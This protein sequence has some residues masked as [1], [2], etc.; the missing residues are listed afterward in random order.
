MPPITLVLCLG[1]LAIWA[2]MQILP[3][4]SWAPIA[5]RL[6]LVPGDLTAAAASGDAGALAAQLVTLITYA[7]IHVE[8]IHVFANV[9]FLLAFG[10]QCERQ[11]GPRRY[12]LLLL[13][14]TVAGGVA[15]LVV[16]GDERI[17]ILGASAATSGLMGAFAWTLLT[18][19][20]PQRRRFGIGIV[21]AFVVVNALFAL[22]GGAIAGSASAV[23][24]QAHLAGFVAGMAFGV[25]DPVRRMLNGARF[26]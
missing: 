9:G 22:L 8:T 7:V 18:A 2:L 10:S 21:I 16:L 13:A 1:L 15:E 11:M 14:A 20:N 25:T 6:V 5:G 4:E 3:F 17:A 23:A 19:V 26:H 12:L 24:W